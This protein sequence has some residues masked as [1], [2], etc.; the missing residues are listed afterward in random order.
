LLCS[1]AVACSRTRF[2]IDTAL[3]DRTNLDSTMFS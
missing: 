1:A 2:T 3:P